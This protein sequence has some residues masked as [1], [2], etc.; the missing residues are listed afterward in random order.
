MSRFG[1]EDQRRFWSKVTFGYRDH[2]CWLWTGCLGRGGYGVF[3]W[4]G[5]NLRAH[6]VA[7]EVERGPVPSGLQ[8]LH[9]C[10]RPGCVNPA[11]LFLGTDADNMRDRDRKDR[12][13]RGR[14]NGR[15]RLTEDAIRD[16]RTRVDGG[17]PQRHV[18]D[19]YGVGKTTIGQIARRET[20]EHVA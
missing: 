1:I 3:R 17:Q 8:V 12:G 13:P 4:C 11:H 2:N 18:A 7:W 9:R 10:D 16:I 14:R 15:A 6:R 5:L 19:L 20:W